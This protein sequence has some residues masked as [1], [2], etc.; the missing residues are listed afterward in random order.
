MGTSRFLRWNY[1]NLGKCG[2]N[3]GRSHFL[4][5]N[6]GKLS[7][8]EGAQARPA[9]E[10]AFEIAEFTAGRPVSLPKCCILTKKFSEISAKSPCNS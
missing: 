5:R 6:Y 3:M 8:F 10:I 7:F 9:E 2:G 1:N 4:R